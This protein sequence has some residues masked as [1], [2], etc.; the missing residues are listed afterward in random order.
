VI[1]YVYVAH[2]GQQADSLIVTAGLYAACCCIHSNFYFPCRIFSYT[3]LDKL[4]SF[5]YSIC[6]F[7]WFHPI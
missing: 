6:W 2:R 4:G 1:S 7:L 3:M 5:L